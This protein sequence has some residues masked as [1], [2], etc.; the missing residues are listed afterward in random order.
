[1]LGF[2]NISYLFLVLLL[3]ATS[4]SVQKKSYKAPIKEEG[5]DYLLSKMKANQNHFES[6]SGKALVRVTNDGKKSEL[7]VN[8]RIQ[9]DSLIWVS[10]SAGI[11]IEAARVI[12]TRDTVMF[13]NRLDNT[14]FIGN[15]QF[16]SSLIN[17]E[18]DFDIV[19]S[20][21]T[22]NDFSW[23]DYQDLKATVTS[24]QY[25]LES[26]NRR[27]LKKHNKDKFEDLQVI[28]QS[29]WLNPSS[30]K[31]ERIKIKEINKDNRKINAEYAQF[32]EIDGQII[33]LQYDIVISANTD[34]IIDATFMKV[35][36]N[37]P[38]SFPFNIPSKYS[39]IK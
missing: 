24:H 9:K 30:F 1:M 26:A 5:V 3:I 4:C 21:L 38:L 20:V 16:I 14:Y 29:M 19:Q 7:K 2:R 28:Y 32:K 23:Y 34:I 12:L 39:E 15:Y 6:L 17:A 36:L 33:P 31:I 10:I 8:L 37:D 25:Q 22:G 27:K 13:I 18:V 11:G 35:N